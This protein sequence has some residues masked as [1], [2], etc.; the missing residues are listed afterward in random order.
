MELQSQEKAISVNS[1]INNVTVFLRGAEI[2]RE[3]SVAI[4]AGTQKLILENLP[5]NI[6]PQSIQVAGLGNFTILGV[7]HRINYLKPAEKT[8]EVTDLDKTLKT[9]QEKITLQQATRNNLMAEEEMLKKNQSIGGSQT[10]VNVT[11]LKDFADF[12]RARLSD[13]TTRTI[14]TAAKIYETQKEIDNINNQL[15]TLQS[16]PQKPTSVITVEITAPAASQIKLSVNYL[17]YNAGWTPSYDLRASDINNPVELTYK[18]NIYQTTG[19]EWLNIKPVLSTANPTLNNAKPTLNPWYLSFY[20]SV[21]VDAYQAFNSEEL[22]SEKQVK[23]SKV[24]MEERYDEMRVDE[25]PALS[26]YESI[27]VQESQ[28]SIEFMI[29]IP[30]TIP[31]DGQSHSVELAKYSLPAVYEYYAVRKLEKDVFL[32]AKVTGWEKLNLLSG[33]ANIFFEGRYVGESNIET[34]QTD[35]MLTLSL[36]R[37]KNITVT[38]IRKRDFSGKQFLGSNIT[39]IREWDL[40]VHN[41]KNQDITIILEDQVPVS[42]E[43]EIKIEDLNISNAEKNTETGKLTWKLTLKPAESHSMNVKYSVKYPKNSK[44][45]LE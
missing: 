22:M 15:R 11:E 4:Q 44:V 18:A 14:E 25:S 31:S 6:N 26:S 8:K 12:Y 5:Q 36:G 28:T 3:G 43:K 35:D 39:E 7:S 20:E 13:L 1:A 38:R 2:Q 32:L 29:D 23:K 16:V 42:T 40:T 27:T 45:V 19:E 24:V 30:Y 33:Q 41:K 9:L 17:V 21:P 37:D 10:G 34:R